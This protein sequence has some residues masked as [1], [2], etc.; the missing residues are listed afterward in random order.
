M[1]RAARAVKRLRLCEP[2]G[3]HFPLVV[4]EAVGDGL[5]MP[6]V[7]A[8]AAA[9]NVCVGQ[10]V[11]KLSVALSELALVATIKGRAGIQFGMAFLGSIAAEAPQAL[12]PVASVQYGQD[13]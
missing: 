2:S 11:H 8:A 9:E 7:G 6:D 5:D 3:A 12:R 10:G 1:A 13:M 4:G